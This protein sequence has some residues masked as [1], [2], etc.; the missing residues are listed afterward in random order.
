VILLRAA[1]AAMRGSNII[2]AII[3]SKRTC[4]HALPERMVAKRIC[5]NDKLHG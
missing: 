2:S 4:L 5:T 1:M 3:V